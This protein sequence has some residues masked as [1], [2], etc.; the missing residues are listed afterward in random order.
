MK[1]TKYFVAVENVI[2]DRRERLARDLKNTSEVQNNNKL[3]NI[4][5]VPHPQTPDCYGK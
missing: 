4:L 3:K 1:F 2:L 5:F